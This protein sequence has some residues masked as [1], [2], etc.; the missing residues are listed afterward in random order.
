VL[1]EFLRL[2]GAQDCLGFTDALQCA[3][4]Q[5]VERLRGQFANLDD[6]QYSLDDDAE[7]SVAAQF[8]RLFPAHCL[9]CLDAL[10]RSEAEIARSGGTAGIL[11]WP[12]VTLVD[13]GCGTGAA[14][15]AVL[16]LIQAYQEFVLATGR[17]LRRVEVQAIGLDPS[18]NMLQVYAA[19]VQ[20]YSQAIEDLMID[21]SIETVAAPFPDGAWELTRLWR[22]HNTHL[23]VAVMSNI[24]RVMTHSFDTGW[25]RWFEKLRRAFDGEP[26]GQPGFGEAEAGGV[27]HLLEAWELDH[28]A[29]LG[30]ATKGKDT[31]S[32]IR[33]HSCLDKMDEAIADGMSPHRVHRRGV[34][35][36]SS[37]FQNPRDSWWREFKNLETYV[38]RYYFDSMIITNHAYASDMQ[39][40]SVIS[41]SNLELAWARTRRHAL[42]E[43]LADEVEV[44][45]LDRSLSE[46]LGRLRKELLLGNWGALNVD[47]MLP[48]DAPK[49]AAATRPRALARLEDQIASAAVVQSLGTKEAAERPASFSYRVNDE[50]DE[51]LYEYWLD[52]WKEFLGDRHRR[53]KSC[54]V[55][56]SDVRGFYENI[57]QQSLVG[58]V[59]RV[60]GVGPRL[61]RLLCA[62]VHRDCGQAHLGGR[63]LPQG[64]VGSGFWADLY[65]TQADRAFSDLPGVSFARYADDMVFAIEGGEPEAAD[66][67]D[68]LRRGLCQLHLEPSERKTYTQSG[69]DYIADTLLDDVLERLDRDRFRPVVSQVY[70]ISRAYR[71][72]YLRDP[73]GF[74]DRYS[75][76]L[77]L[78]PICV[79]RPWLRRKIEQYSG[80]RHIF[81]GQR[82]R[83]PS[84][85]S[86][87]EGGTAWL[88][89]FLSINAGWKRELDALRAELCSLCNESMDQLQS[90]GLSDSQRGVAL[91]RLRF[92]AYR[93]CV[94]G[95]GAT[96]DRVSNQ[97]LTQPWSVPVHAV[98]QA[99]GEAGRDDLLRD[100]L[101]GSSLD[102]VRACAIRALA[103]VDPSP[104]EW[105][106]A[107]MWE[108]LA[109]ESSAPVYKLK[110]SEALLFADCWEDADFDQCAQLLGQT[111]SPYL[112][113]NYV[114]IAARAFPDL[115]SEHLTRLWQTSDHPIVVDAVEYAL[116]SPGGSLVLENEP[117]A[118]LR[119]Y[120]KDY[121][122]AESDTKDVQSPF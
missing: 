88:E 13:I 12:T 35:E 61:D 48:Y 52:L 46:K 69:S 42:H 101:D 1:D 2:M 112:L 19:L 20:R 118:L 121:P 106:I 32:Q 4:S 110:A 11:G 111:V 98:S 65:L 40:R 113:K 33:W 96:A 3:Y 83:F 34:R 62:L 26:V 30:I 109:D 84:Y 14:T 117:E 59:R 18:E 38:E 49:N 79:S 50:E 77:R 31:V 55:L 97:I 36:T 87:G 47:H 99:L 10:A 56:V 37:H 54:T 95:L 86:P 94:L 67:E 81:F 73:W 66:I 21:V 60:L 16:S 82:L 104:P 108:V 76:L 7:G 43:D 17:P 53:A 89:E 102:Y 68:E 58:V 119:Y 27:R 116:V 28:V 45:L 91:R 107:R 64:H 15:A 6:Q 23:A 78:I 114:L 122:V 103:E 39:W 120:S 57:Q 75:Q 8:Y 25:S 24:I 22:P 80:W 5:V 9:K 74:V 63:G 105:A 29:L 44:L 51:F 92:A 41:A 71:R 90:E 93:L 85:P 72:L 115:V 100:I 70:R